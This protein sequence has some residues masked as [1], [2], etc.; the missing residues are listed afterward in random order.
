MSSPTSATICSYV[1]A[2]FKAWDFPAPGKW[3][4]G[5]HGFPDKGALWAWTSTKCGRKA[6]GDGYVLRCCGDGEGAEEGVAGMETAAGWDAPIPL[7]KRSG[8]K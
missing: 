1:C 8:R 5:G 6:A 7:L 3:K 4:C 2:R